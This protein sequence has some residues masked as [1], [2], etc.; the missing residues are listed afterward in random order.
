[1]P[2]GNTDNVFVFWKRW[3]H[4]HRTRGSKGSYFN[5]LR[6]GRLPQVSFLVP[7]Y[8]RGWDE[9][10]PADVSVGMGIQEEIVTALKES[11]AWDTSAYILTYDEHG[12]Y[13][14]HVAPR[15]VDAFGLG[16]RVP[17]WVISPYAKPQHIEST[18]YDHV[19][20]LKFLETV[21]DLPTLASTN[22][23]FD[24][25]TPGGSN[26]EAAN[27]APTGPPAPPRDALEEIGDL[28]ECFAF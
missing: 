2:Y 25:S 26:Y 19:S 15:K 4:D 5:D 17:T 18:V 24:A 13:F 16:I 21:F 28:T 7:S 22:H 8:A 23:L 14:D 9:H 6:R 20:T 27:G 1:V 3:A 10:P 12:G 11:S